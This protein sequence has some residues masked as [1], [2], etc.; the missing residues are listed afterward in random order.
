V[1]P[2]LAPVRV[3]VCVRVCVSVHVCMR[4]CE[5]G[6]KREGLGFTI[7]GFACGPGVRVESIGLG[8]ME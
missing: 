6:R 4:L 7:W 1:Q 5:R 8:F 2:V 3:C